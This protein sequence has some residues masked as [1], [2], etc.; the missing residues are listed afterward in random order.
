MRRDD[1][2]I[3]VE[4]TQ[5]GDISRVPLRSPISG[6]L[7]E[8]IQIRHGEPV[9]LAFR[10]KFENTCAVDVHLALDGT[11]IDEQLPLGKAVEIPTEIDRGGSMTNSCGMDLNH[12]TI[13]VE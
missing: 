1:R 4:E 7:P 2:G 6:S 12:G 5:G 11:R 9:T 8:R 3:T 13:E 10:R